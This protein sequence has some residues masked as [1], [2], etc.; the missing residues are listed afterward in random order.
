MIDKRQQR[1]PKKAPTRQKTTLVQ[2]QHMTPLVI[3]ASSRSSGSSGYDDDN[4][5]RNKNHKSA[6]HNNLPRHDKD[7]KNDDVPAAFEI[8]P[9]A[10]NT[11]ILDSGSGN[12]FLVSS[13]L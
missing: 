6:N 11:A 10:S 9:R 4:D 1:L 7:E 8:S 12:A 5:G 13:S 2:A 3:N